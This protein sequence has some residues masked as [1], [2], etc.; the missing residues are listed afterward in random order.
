MF[1]LCLGDRHRQYDT[2]AILICLPKGH[3]KGKGRSETKARR[4]C[5][6]NAAVIPSC[7][8]QTLWPEACDD[9]FQVMECFLGCLRA[10]VK[11]QMT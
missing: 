2:M 1:P 7:L 9:S 3:R 8:F 10:S 4:K 11:E 6:E 5:K